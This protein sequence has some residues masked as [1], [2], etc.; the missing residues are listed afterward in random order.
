MNENVQNYDNSDNSFF[1]LHYTSSDYIYKVGTAQVKCLNCPKSENEY[2]DV[3][4]T[5]NENVDTEDINL[6]NENDS[7]KTVSVKINGKEVIQTTTGKAGSLSIK[8]GVIIK[9]K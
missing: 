2:N 9:N 1:N 7:I 4:G 8:N 3:E 6:T 5:D